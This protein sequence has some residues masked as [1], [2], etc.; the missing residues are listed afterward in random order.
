MVAK[1]VVTSIHEAFDRYLGKD[2]PA[3]VDKYRIE[4]ESAI[5]LI[6][7]AGGIPVLAHPGLLKPDGC[8]GL[9]P[10]VAGLKEMG[11]MGIEAYYSGHSP[12]Q[13][14]D[15]IELA[16]R[17]ELLITGGTDFHGDMYPDIQM[18]T[19]RGDMHV[20]YELY[21]KLIRARS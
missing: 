4:A 17:Y 10:L 12:A 20:P 13:T 2:K 19:G 7:S 14:A 15:Y 18:G 16:G 3:Y 8:D 1:G 11:L 9:T 6:R 21:E 5:R